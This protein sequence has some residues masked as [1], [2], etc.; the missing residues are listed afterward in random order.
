VLADLR[1]A[2]VVAAPSRMPW[3]IAKS[4]DGRPRSQC[5]PAVGP[6][7]VS[8][9]SAQSSRR[10]RR[11]HRAG[12]AVN[13]IAPLMRLV[14]GSRPSGPRPGLS[15]LDF[16]DIAR[17]YPEQIPVDQDEIGPLARL[18]RADAR[19][20]VRSVGRIQREGRKASIGVM[21]CSGCQPPGGWPS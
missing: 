16:P 3:A 18:E 20:P 4:A 1:G 11:H 13:E 7:A 5:A 6:P 8:L 10:R 9:R 12:E 19:L 17:W 15:H 21:A 14:M 2:E